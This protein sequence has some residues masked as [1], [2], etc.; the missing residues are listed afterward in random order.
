MS[1]YSARIFQHRELLEHEKD[2][3]VIRIVDKYLPVGTA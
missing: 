1:G 2:G 3:T